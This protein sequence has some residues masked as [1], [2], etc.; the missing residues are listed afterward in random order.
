M[1]TNFCVHGQGVTLKTLRRCVLLYFWTQRVTV[2]ICTCHHKIY[3]LKISHSFNFNPISITLWYESNIIII[4]LSIV[5]DGDK[6]GTMSAA[7]AIFS[8]A[9]LGKPANNTTGF[10]SSKYIIFSWLCSNFNYFVYGCVRNFKSTLK[11]KP[12][13]ELH[14]TTPPPTSKK[15]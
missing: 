2:E 4:L 6:W 8:D 15:H 12:F 14:W 5:M 11:R 3:S 7:V 9:V 13:S 10:N 1:V